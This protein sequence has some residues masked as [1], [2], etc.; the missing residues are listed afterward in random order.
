MRK[1]EY[2]VTIYRSDI[3][4]LLAFVVGMSVKFRNLRRSLS[5]FHQAGMCIVS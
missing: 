5:E 1:L 2:F 3:S 4:D